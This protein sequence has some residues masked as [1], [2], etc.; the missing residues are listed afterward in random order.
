MKVVAIIPCRYQ[1]TRLP[2]KPLALID[3]KPMM[4]HV[5]QR[6]LSSGVLDEIYIATDDL[7]IQ[8]V[9][10]ALNLKV[11][12]TADE[13]NTGSDRVAEAAQSIEA[14]YYINIQGD[15][16]LIDPN[17]IRLVVKEMVNCEDATVKAVNAYSLLSEAVDIMDI[18]VVKVITNI[19]NNALAFSR[20][21]IPYPQ[22]G[23]PTKYYK[24]LGL[25]IIS[26]SGINVFLNHKPQYLEQTEGVEMYRLLE[27]GHTIKM[28]RV[29]DNSISVDTQ[30]DLIK[31]N[32]IVQQNQG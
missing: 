5:Y 10:N 18:N 15:E 12:M 24:Q 16:P 32:K 21:P 3:G 14:D 26:Q 27:L 1:S 13:H 6:A 25:Y 11:I 22:S 28:L 17:T 30:Q 29:H 4:W 23:L 31:V 7:R 8:E 19:K 9:A 20:Q 2:G